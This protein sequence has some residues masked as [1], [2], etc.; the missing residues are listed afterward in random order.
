MWLM[1]F[2]YF[3]R[4]PGCYLITKVYTRNVIAYYGCCDK[5]YLMN[6]T[7]FFSQNPIFTHGDY[8]ASCGKEEDRSRR[9]T[10]SLLAY[11]ARKGRL[12]RLRRGLYATV[13][14]GGKPDRQPVDPH[15]IASKLASDSVLAYHTAL[16]FH[17]KS[18]S[19]HEQITYLTALPAKPFRFRTQVFRAVSFPKRLTATSQ[20]LFEVKSLEKS[21]LPIRVSSLERTLV[22]VLDRPDLAG[23][24]EEIWRSLELVEYFALD[25]VIEYALLLGNATT[26]AKTGFYLEQHRET[27]M[28]EEQHLK[29]LRDRRPKSP[30]YLEKP[31]GKG[32]WVRDWNLIVPKRIIDRVWEE[33]L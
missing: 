19:V 7:A 30:R 32:E 15:I 10:D 22:D 5:T 8:L 13:E 18:Y 24:W 4:Q 2:Y 6:S 3:L 23:G 9:T 31:T 20:Q 14:F 1:E 25:H 21:G 29:P 11:H 28:V 12:L 16:E 26:I 33:V 17:G 27:L